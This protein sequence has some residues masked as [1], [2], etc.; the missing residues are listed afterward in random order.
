L[1]AFVPGYV[2]LFGEWVMVQAFLG[3]NCWH[4]PDRVKSQSVPQI[5]L[6]LSVDAPDESEVLNQNHA[7]YFLNTE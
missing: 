4:K 3:A 1:F 2:S 7:I 6:D 5:V